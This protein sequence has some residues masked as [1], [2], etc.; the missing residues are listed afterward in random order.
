MVDGVTVWTSTHPGYW[1]S[2]DV[3]MSFA[4]DPFQ[5]LSLKTSSRR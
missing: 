3:D 5:A 4:K 2:E 1:C